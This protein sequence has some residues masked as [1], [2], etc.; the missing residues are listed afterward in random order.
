TCGESNAPMYFYY[1]SQPLSEADLQ[2]LQQVKA[3]FAEAWRICRDHNIRFVVAVIP[4][5][6]RVYREQCRFEDQSIYR[7][8]QPNH[9][10]EL[11]RET[12]AEV[13]PEIGFV[14]LTD[15]L[16]EATQQGAHTYFPDDTHWTPKGNEVAGK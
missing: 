16:R 10:P 11:L 8:W 13:S 1:R 7:F 9:L 4:T 12:L 5:K 3:I 15:P 2:T 14:D 6:Y